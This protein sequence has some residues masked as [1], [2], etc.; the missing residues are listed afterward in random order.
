MRK[1]DINN[2]RFLEKDLEANLLGHIQEFLLELGRGF[3][4]I[5]RQ[6]R[7]MSMG[8]IFI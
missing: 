6:K 5:A 7:S 3:S 2:R 4:F 1:L 8:I